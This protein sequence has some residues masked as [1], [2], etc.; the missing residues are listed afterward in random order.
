MSILLMIITF[1]IILV[2]LYFV[3][4]LLA[5]DV[6]IENFNFQVDGQGMKL[7]LNTKEKNEVQPTSRPRSK[8][9]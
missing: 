5:K 6:F 4:A 3:I 9:K 7:N 2:I 8:K 1:S